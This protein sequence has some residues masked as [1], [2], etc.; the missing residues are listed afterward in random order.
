MN[1]SILKASEALVVQLENEH[2]SEFSEE[3]IEN[4]RNEIN[5]AKNGKWFLLTAGWHGE[6]EITVVLEATQDEEKVKQTK[7]EFWTPKDGFDICSYEFSS[8]EQMEEFRKNIL[9]NNYGV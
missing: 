1:E 6:D 2:L 9:R 5:K 8:Y 7:E 3:P 4:L